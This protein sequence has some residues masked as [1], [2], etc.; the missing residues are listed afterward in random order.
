MFRPACCASACTPRTW[1]AVSSNEMPREI[2]ENNAS[3]FR[4][5]KAWPV[6]RIAAISLPAPDRQHELDA[7]LVGH[8]REPDAVGP[9]SG[10]ALRHRR[11]RATG[12]A[13]GAEKAQLEAIGATHR[14]ALIASNL[15]F[16]GQNSR[17]VLAAI[18]IRRVPITYRGSG[19]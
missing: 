9:A 10:P 7:G 8:L 2:V 19:C 1:R 18:I 12:G 4:I 3:Q 5:A 11:N 15:G 14:V 13:V 17:A 16:Q 6:I